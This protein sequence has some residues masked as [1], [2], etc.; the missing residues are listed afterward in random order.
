M[1]NFKDDS[2][3]SIY[4]NIKKYINRENDIKLYKSALI[5]HA[6]FIPFIAIYNIVAN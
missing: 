6:S 4:S 2:Y 3:L 1:V 5:S